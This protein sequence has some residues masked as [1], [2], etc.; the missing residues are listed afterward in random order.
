MSPLLLPDLH[1]LQ[2][3]P[4]PL[5]PRL[6]G[7]RGRPSHRRHRQMHRGQEELHPP[8][9]DPLRR[10]RVQPA[11]HG[12][13]LRELSHLLRRRQTVQE[14]RSQDLQGRE[15]DWP[16]QRPL[17]RWEREQRRQRQ[18]QRRRKWGQGQ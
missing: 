13:L 16:R 7:R 8:F 11:H 1:R 2:P 5:T 9:V 4:L 12:Q 10:V 15:R 3:D 18:Q 14:V 6:P 17:G